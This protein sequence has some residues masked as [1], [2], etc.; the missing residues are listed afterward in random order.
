[1]LVE[2]VVVG[3][4]PVQP[5]QPQAVQVAVELAVMVLLEPLRLVQRTLAVAAVA[6]VISNLETTIGPGQMVALVL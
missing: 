2:A 5:L 6:L 1:M 4:T 3:E